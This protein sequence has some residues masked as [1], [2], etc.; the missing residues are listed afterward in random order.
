[1]GGTIN[2]IYQ[3][4]SY[5]LNLQAENLAQLQEQAATGSK[6]NRASD[7]PSSAYRVLGLNS[8]QRTLGGY[9]DTISQTTSSLEI[10]LTII[11]EMVSGLADTKVRV[12]QVASGLYGDSGRASVA[13]G[14]NNTLEQMVSLANTQHMNEYLFGGGN[15]GSAPYA[16]TRTDGRITSVTYQGSSQNRLIEVAAGVQSSAFYTGDEIFQSNS[17]A[18]I[19]FLGD[20]GAAAG[21]G[22]SSVRGDTWLTVTGSAGN[23]NLSIDDGLTTVNT[24]GT[25]TNLAVTHSTT[26]EVLYVDTT[27]ISAAGTDMVRAPGTYNVFETLIYVRDILNNDK[28]L[29]DAQLEKLRITSLESLEEVRSCLTDKSV[30]VGSRIGFL[31]TLK[32]SVENMK[33]GTEDETMMLQEA[34]IAQIAIGIAR[35]EVLYQMSLSVAGSLMS[36]SLLDFIE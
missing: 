8:Q 6:I 30:S 36:M 19:E 20:T 28:E 15:T 21:T 32:E 31:E 27:G 10:S 33:F 35:Q 26:G 12:S 18:A 2:G 11:E 16:V 34:D 3:N 9:M 25:D 23:Y 17:R 22:T 13:E 1:M 14:I 5:A 4:L 29:S 24:D 7:D